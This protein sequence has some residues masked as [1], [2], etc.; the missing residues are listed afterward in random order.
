MKYGCQLEYS[1]VPLVY[2]LLHMQG[3]CPSRLYK[4]GLLYRARLPYEN[5]TLEGVISVAQYIA[6]VARRAELPL[7][8]ARL[9]NKTGD[10]ITVAECMQVNSRVSGYISAPENRDR[11]VH[12]P[13]LPAPPAESAPPNLSDNDLWVKTYCKLRLQHSK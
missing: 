2:V 7:V 5:Q 6:K 3:Y 9:R 8:S 1:Q 13:E 4:W 11:F 12:Q 10:G